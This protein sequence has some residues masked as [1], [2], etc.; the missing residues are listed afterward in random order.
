MRGARRSEARKVRELARL[1][2]ALD[3]QAAVVRPRPRRPLRGS[4]SLAR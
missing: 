1:L 3:A 2:A 4:L